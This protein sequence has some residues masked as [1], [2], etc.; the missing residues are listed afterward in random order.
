MTPTLRKPAEVKSRKRPARV[1]AL[2]SLP[3]FFPLEG[4]KVLLAG[5]SDAAAWKAELLAAAGAEVHIY[6]ENLAP[7][8]DGLIASEN[9]RGR[10]VHHQRRWSVDSFEGAVLAVADAISDGE[11]QAFACAAR[12]KGLPVNVI[13]KPAFCDF[14]FGSIVN[15]SPVVIGISTYGVAPILGQAI[16]RRIETLMPES[17]QG[18]AQLASRLRE[19][20]LSLL[21]AGAQR[22]RFW[23]R[24]SD[25]AFSGKSAPVEEEDL[26]EAL[27]EDARSS[28]AGKVT[29]VG[30]GPGD[31]EYL[32]LKAVRAL[33][34]AD[35]IL[36]DDLVDDAVLELARREA[37]RMLVG[38]RGGRES[39]RQ[40]DIND[41]MVSLAQQGKHVVR[42][43]CGDPMIFGRGGE[44]LDRLAAEG[45]PATVVPGITAASAMAAR[46]GISLTH[47]DHAQSVRF[48]T[49]HSR[50][51]ELPE[52][53]DWHGLTDPATSTVFYMGAR[54]AGRIR[55]RLVQE[56]LSPA[57]PVVAV[58]GISRSDEQCWSGALHELEKGV[59]S[60]GLEGPILIGVGQVFQ[61]ANRQTGQREMSEFRQ[62]H[63]LKLETAGGENPGSRTLGNAAAI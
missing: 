25:L 29:L 48:V 17:L 5:G 36:F 37:K 12:A 26:A 11:A 7:A 51:G 21:E 24:I 19:K 8:F 9:S 39:C 10:I 52:T 43:K 15:R 22:R 54:M 14:Q 4:R 57:T 6:S 35:V 59:T 41:M 46:L 38:K 32:T 61:A 58:S 60:L 20:T 33:Q 44:E 28:A 34:S 55:D 45:I 30:A 53:V 18:W 42:L 63:P 40:E 50:H 1:G 47:R 2:A 56:G 16:R 49:G 23:E 3:L 13:D 31:A 62:R 27:L